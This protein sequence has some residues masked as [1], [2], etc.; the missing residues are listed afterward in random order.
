MAK[1]H[2]KVGYIYTKETSPGVY[3]EVVT[4]R[5]CVGDILRNNKRWEKSENLNDDIT[6]S[7]T[8]SILTDEYIN[9]NIK[10]LRYIQWMGAKWKITSFEIQR[11]RIILTVGGVYNG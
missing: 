9:Q 7:N 2:G 8:F 6:V 5:D 1:F 4:E 10:N 3:T 11:P